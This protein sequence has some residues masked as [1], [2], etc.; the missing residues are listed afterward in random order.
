[1]QGGLA[2]ECLTDPPN[3]SAHAFSR[4]LLVSARLQAETFHSCLSDGGGVD[5]REG[6][7]GPAAPHAVVPPLWPLAETS[8]TSLL[9]IKLFC[10]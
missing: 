5:G 2:P 1:M 10:L 4:E 8:E 6:Q 3:S 7:K 9:P